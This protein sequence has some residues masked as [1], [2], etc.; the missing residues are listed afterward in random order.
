MW[1]VNHFRSAKVNACRPCDVL[2][3]G[4]RAHEDGRDQPRLACVDSSG[5]CRFLARVRHSRRH[6]IQAGALL[7]KALVFAGSGTHT[8]AATFTGA[9]IALPVSLS[10]KVS[11]TAS[12]TPHKR[13]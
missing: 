2:D 8:V 7:K 1:R 3:F 12:A 6:W 10:R 5:Q 9:R 13:G 4:G 11:T